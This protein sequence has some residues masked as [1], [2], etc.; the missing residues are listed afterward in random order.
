MPISILMPALSPTMLDGN[1][2]KWHKKEGEEISSGE[3]IAEIETDKATMELEATSSGKLARI[4]VPEGSKKVKVGELIA[5]IAEEGENINEIKGDFNQNPDSNSGILTSQNIGVKNEKLENNDNNSQEQKQ[6]IKF[7]QKQTRIFA[8]PLARNIAKQNNIELENI[9]GTGPLGRIVKNDVFSYIEKSK[10]SR[11]I[12]P[13]ISQL[14]N[15]KYVTNSN[16]RKIIAQRLQEAKQTIPHFYLT[17]D[18]VVNKLLEIREE[19]NEFQNLKANNSKIS[20]N[21]FIIMACSKALK[22]NPRVNASWQEEAICYYEDIDISVAVAIDEGLVTPI[23]KNADKKNI[24][25]ISKDMKELAVKAKNNKLRPEEFQGGGFTI[26]N[27]GMYGIKN[28]QAIINPPQSA[29]LAVGATEERPIIINGQINIAKIMTL[30]LSCDHR[31]VD[32]AIGA[33]FLSSL[34]YYIENPALML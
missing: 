25:T 21:D 23:I 19:F 28:F 12:E 5:L 1:L 2:A 27:L 13:I 17:I 29:I 7:Y 33:K 15:V 34:K 18:C 24:A 32:G 11:D 30:T 4:I 22:D 14:A 26:S 6:E 20:V 3:V 10:Q 9:K 8:S 31:V 16:I